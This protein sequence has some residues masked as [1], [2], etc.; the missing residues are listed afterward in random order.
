M[1]M[2]LRSWTT[3]P[4]ASSR[5]SMDC[6]A[7]SSG[8]M[9]ARLPTAVAGCD[10]KPFAPGPPRQPARGIAVDVQQSLQIHYGEQLFHA[11]WAAGVMSFGER[12][13]ELRR[14]KN[15]SQR[16]LAE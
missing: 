15:L 13:R 8:V 6:R 1:F 5:R 7:S 11:S 9:A 10:T 16:A 14:A 3:H 4:P 2:L 12:L